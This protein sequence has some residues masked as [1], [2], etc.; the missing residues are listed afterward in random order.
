MENTYYKHGRKKKKPCVRRAQE[1]VKSQQSTAD[2]LPVSKSN[3]KRAGKRQKP[4]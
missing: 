1:H 2:F 4:S 3:R